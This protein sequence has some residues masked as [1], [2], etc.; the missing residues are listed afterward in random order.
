M[1]VEVATIS[2]LLGL[3]DQSRRKAGATVLARSAKLAAARVL[4]GA[5]RQAAAESFIDA[6]VALL[7]SPLAG[8]FGDVWKKASDLHAYTDPRK[9]APGEIH[10]YTLAGHDIALKRNPVIELVLDGAPTGLQ[11]EF[12]LKLSL[13]VLSAVLRIRDGYIIGARLGDFQGAGTYS[14]GSAKLVERKTERF[15]L[16]GDIVFTPGVAL[17]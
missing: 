3:D 4:P 9:H 16:P 2:A 1:T 17:I 10:E 13:A 5:L 6:S 15:R 7:D 8:I 11:L 12:E 14:C